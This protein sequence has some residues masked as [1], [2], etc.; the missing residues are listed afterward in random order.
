MKASLVRVPLT[1]LGLVLATVLPGTACSQSG[2]E[3]V[4]TGVD[5]IIFMKRAV[6]SVDPVTNKVSIDVSGG[7]GQV[8][9]YDRYVP[10]GSLVMLK[11][12]RPDG[13]LIDFTKA[14][15]PNADFNGVD[16]SFDAQQAVF[17][18]KPDAERPLPHLHG[19]ARAGRRRQVHDP[20]A[21][22]DRRRR[23][24]PHLRPRAAASS[25]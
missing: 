21:H 7:N 8:I 1:V 23:R 15:F 25:S 12:P 10:G 5:A 13:Q 2:T 22:G 4:N 11:P 16:V 9:D 18:M 19:A 17:S 24:Q 6:Q 20:P 14:Q 3:Q